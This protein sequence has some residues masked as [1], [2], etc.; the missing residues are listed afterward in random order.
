MRIGLKIKVVEE[1]STSLGSLL[2]NPDLSGC[3]FL[4]FC[5]P[6]VGPSHLRAGANY[7]GVFN[8]CLK[9]Y[10]SKSCLW[11]KELGHNARSEHA[12]AWIWASW[13]FIL[14]WAEKPVMSRSR[15]NISRLCNWHWASDDSGPRCLSDSP[16][17][18][19]RRGRAWSGWSL[20][21]EV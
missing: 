21:L 17:T 3:F 4:D 20:G 7:T 10:R 19:T 2:T 15:P 1:S 14:A 16:G 8:I 13:L 12:H 18:D 9:R 5:M 6:D 11:H